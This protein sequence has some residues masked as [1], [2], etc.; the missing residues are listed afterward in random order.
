MRRTL[1]SVLGEGSM[2]HRD[3]KVLMR[4]DD[5]AIGRQLL[6]EL[7][8]TESDESSHNTSFLDRIARK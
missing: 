7:F 5:T 1:K 3:G 6:K 8:N 2:S 4:R